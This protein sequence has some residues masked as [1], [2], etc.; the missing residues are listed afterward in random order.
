MFD[1]N[2]YCS[3]LKYLVDIDSNSYDPFGVNRIAD[4]FEEEFH[5]IGW[6]V[7]RYHLDDRV[8][9]YLE[10][11]NRFTGHYDVMMIGHMDTVL[12]KGTVEQRPFRTENNIAYGPGVSDMKDGILAMLHIAR[13][14]PASILEQLDICMAM[15]PDEEIGSVYSR[16]ITE[17]IA[18]KS[19]YAFV[20]EGTALN[21]VY[22]TAR[23]GAAR[24]EIEFFGKA[25]HSGYIL[26]RPSASAVLEMANWIV[27]LSSLNNIA[28]KTSVNVG[29]ANGGFS[30]NVVP[31]YAKISMDVRYCCNSALDIVEQ[32][33]ARLCAESFVPGTRVECSKVSSTPPMVP[34]DATNEYIERVKS[35]FGQIGMPFSLIGIRGGGS[36]GNFIANVGTICLDSLGPRGGGGHSDREYLLIDQVEECIIRMIALIKEIAEHKTHM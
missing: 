34:T 22:T 23:K 33:I 1:I 24:F 17:E 16:G 25:E 14:L 27:A 4:F 10:I 28:E 32:E 7:K 11:A 8:G 26:E 13:E 3:D 5:K 15:N 35:V 36:D 2:Q 12:P 20:M 6:H 21:G 19:E 29:V 31:D 18:R 9:D 30:A